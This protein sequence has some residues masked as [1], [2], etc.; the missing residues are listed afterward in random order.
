MAEQ[1]Y[2]RNFAASQMA[3]KNVQ[4][5]MDI[6]AS[7][8]PGTGM[9]ARMLCAGGTFNDG[10]VRNAVS[11]DLEKSGDRT[12]RNVLYL[13]AEWAKHYGCG[14]CGEQS[15]MAFVYLKGQSIGPLDWMQIGNFKHAFVVIGRKE[16]SD[17]SDYRTWGDDSVVCDP[18][19]G[20]TE[21]RLFMAVMNWSPNLL[22]R[23]G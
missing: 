13:S 1:N 16:D 7:N 12:W 23:E 8:K 4:S 18:W 6:G 14:N 21:S 15:A 10:A 9:I 19:A 20:R 5:Q 22:H 2:K 11:R 17:S 3:V